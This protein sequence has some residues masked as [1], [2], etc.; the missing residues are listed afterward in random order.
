MRDGALEKE[1]RRKIGPRQ[2]KSHKGDFGRILILA[3]ARGFAGAAHLAGMGAVRSGAGLV[4]VGVPESIYTIVARREAEVM[5]RPLPSTVQ[6]TLAGAALKPVLALIKGCG[7][8]AMGPGLSQQD[9]TQRLIRSLVHKV[10]CPLI[11][12]ADALN[13]F[14]G[15]V[16]L[17]S[18]ALCPRILTPHTGEFVRL[19]GGSA[20][21]TERERCQRALEAAKKSNSIVVLKG[22]RT[23]VAEPGGRIWCNPTGN[24]GMATGGTGDVLTGVMASMCGRGLPLL[25]AA[26]FAVYFH[27]LAGDLAA[28]R[29]GETGLAASDLIEELPES[30]RRVLGR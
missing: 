19:F 12:D 3:G 7:V 6:G 25:D 29:K 28:R 22:H 30:F 18:Q 24:P 26:R 2:K 27:G 8:M 21:R 10:T 17:L 4:T 13:A 23:V 11:L 16:F 20:P 1:I 15:K 14:E 5:V 9:A